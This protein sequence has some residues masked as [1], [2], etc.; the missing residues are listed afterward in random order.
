MN[1]KSGNT[2]KARGKDEVGP[3]RDR[4]AECP[5]H[6]LGFEGEGGRGG[7]G[8]GHVHRSVIAVVEYPPDVKL[9][10][11]CTFFV[12]VEGV[13]FVHLGQFFDY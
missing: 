10:Q 11:V 3:G 13:S 12:A 6:F 8:F 7:V 1:R 9:G 4:E 2:E 5:D